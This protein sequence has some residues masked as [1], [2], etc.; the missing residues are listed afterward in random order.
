MGR[1]DEH[2]DP[3]LFENGFRSLGAAWA[4]SVASGMHGI[5]TGM[6]YDDEKEHRYI[7]YLIMDVLQNLGQEMT[8]YVLI[9]QQTRTDFYQKFLA[10]SLPIFFLTCCTTTSWWRLW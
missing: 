8:K 10:E 7:V 1:Q 2:I 4:I 6:Q 9:C 3:R 5:I